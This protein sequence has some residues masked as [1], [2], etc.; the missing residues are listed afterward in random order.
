MHTSHLV[1]TNTSQWLNTKNKHL[2]AGIPPGRK[3]SHHGWRSSTATFPHNAVKLHRCWEPECPKHFDCRQ[4]HARP[5][6]R[7]M[8]LSPTTQQLMAS[9]RVQRIQR[10]RRV[11]LTAIVPQAECDQCCHH[12]PQPRVLIP[13]KVCLRPGNATA[14]NKRVSSERQHDAYLGIDDENVA[15]FQDTS[16]H[17]RF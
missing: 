5:S 13:R 17:D 3:S 10:R 4:K 15:V 8:L 16:N 6:E 14:L 1:K 7:L 9:V 2:D 11:P 12:P